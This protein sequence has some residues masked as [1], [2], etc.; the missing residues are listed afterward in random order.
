MMTTKSPLRIGTRESR[1]ALVQAR[2]VSDLL[3]DRLGVEAEIVGLRTAGDADQRPFSI[4]E[5]SGFFTK[6]I[7]AAVLDGR[8]DIAVHSLKDLET[9]TDANLRLAAILERADP[10][11]ALLVADSARL[12]ADPEEGGLAHLPQGAEVGTS[13]LRRRAFLKRLRPD[14]AVKPLRG[15][16]PTRIRK[17]QSGEYAAIVLAVAGLERLGLE[18]HIYA[19]LSEDEFLPAPGQGAI[20]VQVRADAEPVLAMVSVLDHTDTHQAVT[21]ERSFLRNIEG[22]CQA[23][24]GALARVRN[25]RVRVEARVCS[26]DG[27][28]TADG[29]AEGPVEEA[30]RVGEEAARKIEAAGGRE[31]LDEIRAAAG[32]EEGF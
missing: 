5:G 32:S 17:L 8:V 12:E 26:V 10:R 1:L 2:L 9:T 23:P 18:E 3:R 30:A 20:A 14:L 29:W 31:I 16:V 6:E 7:E 22:G 25:G 4:V 28:R 13:S 21:A 24:A 15:N 11:D 19:R 27:D